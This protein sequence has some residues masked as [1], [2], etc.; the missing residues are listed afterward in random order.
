M[1]GMQVQAVAVQ[2]MAISTNALLAWAPGRSRRPS[3]NPSLFTSLVRMDARWRTHDVPCRSCR[4]TSPKSGSYLRIYS[5][6]LKPSAVCLESSFHFA[7]TPSWGIC[8]TLSSD[9]L[10]GNFP[11]VWIKQF[12]GA[13]GT[14]VMEDGD[15]DR[16][17]CVLPR[18]HLQHCLD[19]AR[20]L[21]RLQWFSIRF[22]S[23]TT[24][25][26]LS[27][28]ALGHDFGY[29]C[30]VLISHVFETHCGRSQDGV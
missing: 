9:D 8:M 15:Y 26:I 30:D 17:I 13:T 16:I 12:L 23:L 6:L 25:R 3:T 21:V 28:A 27:A 4:F 20:C 11:R 18:L 19:R 24:S 10:S 5:A 7:T 22:F 2:C 1:G 14:S 29:I